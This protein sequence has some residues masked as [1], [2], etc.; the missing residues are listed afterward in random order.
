MTP[1]VRI[2]LFSDTITK[3]TQGMRKF[4]AEAE[5]GDEQQKEDPSV[6][7]LVEMVCDLLGKEDAIYLPSGTM[8]NQIAFRV[9]CRPGDEIIMDET[10]HTRHYETGGPAALTGAMTYPLAGIRGVF[11]AAQL[12]AAVRPASNHLPRSKV[13]LVEQTSNLGGGSIWPL[14][15]I[16]SVCAAAHKHGMV[17][18]MDGARLLNAVA[19]TGVKAKTYAEPF[20]SVWID[21]SKGLGA[22]VGAALAGSKGF[23]QE[24]WRWKHQFGGAMRQAG[25]IAA[26]AVYALNHHVERLAEDNENAQILAR[27]L[28]EIEGIV[29]EPV[30]TNL[31][32]FDVSGMGVTAEAFNA[33][34][35]EKGLRIS[36]LGKTR[37]RAV[38]H[39]DVSREQVK[40]GLDI[41]RQVAGQIMKRKTWP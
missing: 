34:L 8:C 11:R 20:D 29:V 25:I 19:T 36:V 1:P 40:E 37:G 33:L 13:V 6:N 24:A 4:M 3:P 10:A 38:T 23:I 26:G 22:P 15:G 17:C 9:H 16:Q 5:V 31:I 14:E 28:A 30:E 27:G 18:H 39:L 12:E 35:M 32:F 7:K 21:F 41:I 2:D